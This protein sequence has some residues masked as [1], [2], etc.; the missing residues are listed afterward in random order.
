MNKR[1]IIINSLAPNGD[2]L[3]KTL[4]DVNPAATPTQ[5]TTFTRA[6]NGLTNNSYASTQSIDRDVVMSTATD[7]KAPLCYLMYPDRPLDPDYVTSNPN[8]RFDSGASITQTCFNDTFINSSGLFCTSSD[9][10]PCVVKVPTNANLVLTDF[11]DCWRARYIE[12]LGLRDEYD[13]IICPTTEEEIAAQCAEQYESD[14]AEAIAAMTACFVEVLLNT[15]KF[16]KMSGVATVD[17]NYIGEY[18]ISLPA[19]VKYSAANF[20][21][22]VVADE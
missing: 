14:G 10:T 7:P 9:A 12:A 1:S 21:F 5:I 8:A 3:Q 4:T 6:L 11:T 18:V 2:K 22:N 17:G 15:K 20:R 16:W 19:T 13:D